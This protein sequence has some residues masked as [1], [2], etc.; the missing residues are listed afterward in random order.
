MN[1]AGYEGLRALRP[2]RRPFILLPLGMGGMAA[3]CVDLDGDTQSS[4]NDPRDHRTVLGLAVR[5]S[6]RGT[7]ISGL[8]GQPVPELFA[9]WFELAAS[10]VLSH[11]L[12]FFLPRREP[13]EFGRRY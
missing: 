11:P 9:R 8:L 5:A 13:W 6:L 2:D 7:G 10:C 4:W 1:Q 12:A 3:P